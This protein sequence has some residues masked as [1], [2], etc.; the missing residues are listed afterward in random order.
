[1]K[2]HLRSTKQHDIVL[3]YNLLSNILLAIITIE[4]LVFPMNEPP[5]QN[6]LFNFPSIPCNIIR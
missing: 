5:I 2:Y 3:S 4:I 1:M 6:Y